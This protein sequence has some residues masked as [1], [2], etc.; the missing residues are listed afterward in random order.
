MTDLASDAD[1]RLRPQ[2][3][4]GS[5]EHARL[6][7]KYPC[8]VCL[9][10]TLQKSV[11]SASSPFTLDHCRRCGGVWF[12]Q[13]EVQRLRKCTPQQ[14][15]QE[16]A[17]MDGVHQMQCHS[18]TTLLQRGVERCPACNWAVT[19]DCPSC[20]VAMH[21]AEYDGVKLDVCRDCKGVWFDRH[22][23]VDIW[24]ME[25]TS[26]LQRRQ[27]EVSFGSVVLLDALTYDPFLV[28]YGAHAAGHVLSA[29]AQAASS[30]PAVAEAAGEAASSVF[31]TIVD[32]LSGIFG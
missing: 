6:E 25:F 11:I 24:K 22:E 30:L 13:G 27:N 9:G 2:A 7:L 12:E 28:F 20:G 17:Q 18:C 4:R 1:G 3:A 8:P 10:A 32:I 23:L 5:P 14:L 19:L 16:I 15:W 29:G 31:E 21:A 26:A